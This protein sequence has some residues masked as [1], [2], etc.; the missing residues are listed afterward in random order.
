[1]LPDVSFCAVGGTSGRET[2]YVCI[3]S[4]PVDFSAL[5]SREPKALRDL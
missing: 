3:V 2:S 5:S 4:K 1:M